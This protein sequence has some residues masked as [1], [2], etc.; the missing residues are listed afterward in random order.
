MAIA[1][2]INAIPN[3]DLVKNL[4]I[5]FM[6]MEKGNREQGT[7]KKG[8]WQQGIGVMGNW[9]LGIGIGK[10]YLLILVFSG[11]ASFLPTRSFLSANSLVGGV[12]SR[13]V[14]RGVTAKVV[15]DTCS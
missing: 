8:N 3:L 4:I 11:R 5:L 7:G 1:L 12:R 15:S 14:S 13:S 2:T 6:G 9:E 10:S